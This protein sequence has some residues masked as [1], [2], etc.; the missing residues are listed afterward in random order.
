M[1]FN[2]L[3]NLPLIIGAV[4]L[5]ILLWVHV[6][7]NKTYEYQIEM[8]LQLVNV[9]IGLIQT[10]AIP[11]AAIVR[12]KTSGKQLFALGARQPRL[13][14]SA[15]EF[16]E[17][18]FERELNDGDA[19]AAFDQVYENVAVISPRN[20]VLHFERQAERNLLVKNEVRLQPA[21][22]Y[23]IVGRPKL[24]PEMIS[25]RGPASVLRSLQSL[26]TEAGELVGLTET[27][28]Q[29]VRLVIPDSLHLSAADSAVQ[30]T[31][32]VEPM[33]ERPLLG[34]SVRPPHGFDAA[35]YG[36]TPA[37]ISIRVGAPQSTADQ[38]SAR[39][40]TVSFSP[41]GDDADSVRVPLELRLPPDVVHLGGNVDSILI[42]RKK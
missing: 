29:L 8:P 19:M 23:L 18:T 40:V 11:R 24:E 30:I 34:L 21:T 26:G 20:L 32:A 39:N 38:V 5:A 31:V 25:V 1:R 36:F 3:H 16:R 10:E 37:T 14:I 41:S 7:T 42:Y 6:A 35:K 27:T 2:P 12:V 17:G 28:T 22:G 9:P 15:A 4:L 13:R 33:L